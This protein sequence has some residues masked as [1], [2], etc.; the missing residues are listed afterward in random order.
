[1][2][3]LA[4]E[5]SPPT[6]VGLMGCEKV[7]IG[8]Y[9]GIEG[10]ASGTMDLMSGEVTLNVRHPGGW[11]VLQGEFSSVFKTPAFDGLLEL[12][13]I[14]GGPITTVEAQ[15]MPRILADAAHDASLGGAE[16]RCEF[17]ITEMSYCDFLRQFESGEESRS[18]AAT[19]RH[20]T[21]SPEPEL[22]PAEP[23]P[24]QRLSLSAHGSV[25]AL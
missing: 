19:A 15:E 13:C 21:Q 2:T 25:T 6:I 8:G 20:E 3:Y 11:A 18:S 23:E 1:M 5:S 24:E 7:W 16:I 9:S 10:S 4:G 17:K 22:E 12:I 14:H